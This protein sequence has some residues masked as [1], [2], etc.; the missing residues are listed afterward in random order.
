MGLVIIKGPNSMQ[1][2]RAAIWG[3]YKPIIS[4]KVILFWA[5]VLGP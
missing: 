4:Q 2:L 3:V 1:K 5:E